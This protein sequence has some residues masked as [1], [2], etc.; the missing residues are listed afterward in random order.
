MSRALRNPARAV[1]LDLF[2]D[3]PQDA[4]LEAIGTAVNEVTAKLGEHSAAVSSLQRR[5][6]E[7]QSGDPSARRKASRAWPVMAPPLRITG[8]RRARR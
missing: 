1:D 8:F 7:L 2:Q 3:V 4:P 6:A 5:R